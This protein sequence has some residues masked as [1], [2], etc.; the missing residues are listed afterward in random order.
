MIKKSIVVVLACVLISLS[1][2]SIGAK[3]ETECEKPNWNKGDKW[4]MG[5]EIDLGKKY[6]ELMNELPIE[7]LKEEEGI[8]DFNG[9]FEGNFG[10]YQSVEV[11]ETSPAYKLEFTR[12][13]GLNVAGSFEVTAM[14]PKEGIYYDVE[15]TDEGWD[16]PQQEIKILMDMEFV[17]AV[18]I[19]G[20]EYYTTDFALEKM[21][22]KEELAFN[23]KFNSKN[24]PYIDEGEY[25]Y[26]WENDREYLESLEVKYNDFNLK[27]G[28]KISANINSVYSP[29]LDIFQFPIEVGEVWNSSSNITTSGNYDG[30]IYYDISGEYQRELEE[31]LSLIPSPID[32]STWEYSHPPFVNGKIEEKT[33]EIDVS[34]EC[35]GKKSIN[36]D[37]G[38]STECFLI[39][40]R[41]N[42]DYNDEWKRDCDDLEDDEQETELTLYFSKDLGYFVQADFY[43]TGDEEIPEQTFSAKAVSDSSAQKFFENKANPNKVDTSIE[44]DSSGFKTVYFGIIA[45]PI[46]IVIGTALLLK[47]RNKIKPQMQSYA[48]F[49]NQPMYLSQYPSNQQPQQFP[50][51]P[52]QSQE[53]FLREQQSYLKPKTVLPQYPQF[54][55]CLNC[56]NVAPLQKGQQIL[57]CPRCGSIYYTQSNLAKPL[58]K[59]K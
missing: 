37:D 41:E 26:D 10:I 21:E 59:K 51:P 13:I 32:L 46:V 55:R 16:V 19:T 56:G 57:F 34:F 30:T 36:L 47:R 44:S 27:V 45:I 15:E 12:G 11:V 24:C 39:Q 14:M 53:Q 2:L 5:I 35:T 28:G 20:F 1:I 7:E 31:N 4:S 50:I 6:K 40:P 54:I 52:P 18:R 48:Q 3:S 17:L 58:Q 9:N 29:P 22:I 49:P 33:E 25:H 8:E 43:V 23:L 42:E 38:S